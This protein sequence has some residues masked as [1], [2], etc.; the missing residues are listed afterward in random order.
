MSNIN[1]SLPNDPSFN[2][3]DINNETQ[4]KFYNSVN[5]L[6]HNP[7]YTDTLSSIKWNTYY[8][9]KYK[10]E[11]NL[12]YFIMFICVLIIILNLLKRNFTYFDDLSYS[13]IIGIILAYSFIHILYILWSIMYKDKLNFDENDYM[14]DNKNVTGKDLNKTTNL[15]GTI[16]SSTVAKS[17]SKTTKPDN[18]IND[19]NAFLF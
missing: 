13:V 18:S 11:N 17:C 6:I 7:A 8:Y 3:Q 12:L 1:P 16:T 9:K 15:D 5:T 4:M 10:A 2:I 19:L 14:F